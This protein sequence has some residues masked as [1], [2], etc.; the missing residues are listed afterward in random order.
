MTGDVAEHGL[1]RVQ[2]QRHEAAENGG[3]QEAAVGGGHGLAE[4]DQA[5]AS[6]STKRFA[7]SRLVTP[8][9]SAV[10]VVITR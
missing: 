6:S 9:L 10:K 1:T 3:I 7:T 4:L 8:S 2:R 5:F